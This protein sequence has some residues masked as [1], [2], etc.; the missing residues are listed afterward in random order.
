[1]IKLSIY[2][3][4]VLDFRFP[5]MSQV[6]RN[7]TLFLYNWTQISPELLFRRTHWIFPVK[8]SSV[9]SSL[10]LV[11]FGINIKRGFGFFFPLPFCCLASPIVWMSTLVI[12][13]FPEV[14]P[15]QG[16]RMV[17]QAC[18]HYRSAPVGF[19]SCLVSQQNKACGSALPWCHL[20]SHCW[21]PRVSHVLHMLLLFGDLPSIALQRGPLFPISWRRCWFLCVKSCEDI[22]MYLHAHVEAK[23]V[24]RNRDYFRNTFLRGTMRQ[25]PFSD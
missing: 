21:W 5:S 11:S 4:S 10:N 16:F 9:T 13:D 12:F 7:V 6:C 3:A 14:P 1:M 24:W 18:A 8:S 23:E 25:I 2:I 17:L 15:G 20:G 22:Y 19:N